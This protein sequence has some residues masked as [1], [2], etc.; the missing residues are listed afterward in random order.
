MTERDLERRAQRR[1]A[2]LPALDGYVSGQGF[3]PTV[4]GWRRLTTILRGHDG[5]HRWTL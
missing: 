2:V 3:C 5:G 1:L 4:R